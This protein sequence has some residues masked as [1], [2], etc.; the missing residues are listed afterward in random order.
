MIAG[1]IWY[2]GEGNTMTASTYQKLFTN[3]ILAWRKAWQKEFPFY[4]VQIAPFTYG[5]KNIG[6]LL[7]EQ[8]AKTLSLAKTGMVVVTDLVDNVKDIHPKNKKDV[9]DRLAKLALAETYGKNT[10]VY[11]S[12]YFK[13]MEIIKDKAILYFDNAPNGFMVKGDSKAKASEF[14]I[15]GDDKNFLPAEVKL[16]K[17]R[18]IV[19]SKQVKVPAAVRFAFS[20][21]AMSNVFSKEGLPVAPFRTDDWEVDISKVTD[22]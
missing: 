12:P 20:N 5:N 2:Q 13:K 1:T 11:N 8:Q 14:Y 3:M 9:A 19:F 22:Q 4:F 18:I 7:R 15:A 21:T 17:D 6:A 16:E 10:G